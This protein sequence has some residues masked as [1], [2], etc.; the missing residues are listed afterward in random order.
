MRIRRRIRL[1]NLL[2]IRIGILRY[3]SILSGSYLSIWSGF[4]LSIWSGSYHSLFS[5]FGPSNAPQWPSKVFHLF[6]LMR[7][8][9]LIFTLMRIRIQIQL[10]KISW[11]GIRKTAKVQVLLASSNCWEVLPCYIAI[12][13]VVV[14]FLLLLC[15]Y[16]HTPC[17]LNKT[18]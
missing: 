8:R 12:D 11:I 16:E 9:I 2:R 10:P 7:I 6:T 17:L 5:R 15:T 18:V 14:N 13:K 4:Y 3:L 1:F